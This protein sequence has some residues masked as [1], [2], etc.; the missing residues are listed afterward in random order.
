MKIENSIVFP[1][2]HDFIYQGMIRNYAYLAEWRKIGAGYSEVSILWP[3]KNK[4]ILAP[5]P[6]DNAVIAYSK[7]RFGYEINYVSPQ[8]FTSETAEDFLRDTEAMEAIERFAKKY[9]NIHFVS[10]G[11]TPGAYQLLKKINTFNPACIADMPDELNACTVS[12]YDSKIGFKNLCNKLKLRVPVG[13][14]CDSMKEAIDVMRTLHYNQ[15]SFLLKA[16]RGAA[17]FGNIKIGSAL[18][19]QPF[20]DVEEYITKNIK[21]LP[22]FESGPMLVEEFVEVP[23]YIRHGDSDIRSGFVSA[24]ILANGSTQIIAG[25]VDIHGESGYYEGARLGKG[26]FQEQFLRKLEDIMYRLGN[27]I[28]HNGYRG[29]WGINYMLNKDGEIT[30]IEMNPRRCGES[31][32]HHIARE[33]AGDSWM[34]SVYILNRLPISIKIN[35][36]LKGA[37]YED[38]INIII[39]LNN[40]NK[41]TEII[42]VQLSWVKNKSFPGLGYIII[43]ND[44]KSVNNH[45]ASLLNGLKKIGISTW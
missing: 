11:A 32:I 44:E 33:I 17:G 20:N 23:S 31:H 30:L 5:K 3:G 16:D 12:K 10:W 8:R 40:N 14:L 21:D 18:L 22:Y 9:G 45:E 29:H 15:K 38:I 4:L 42:P 13:Y 41:G 25:G 6:I 36:T 39:G 19:S 43:G 37:V 28:A 24:E 1:N 34:Q 2:V 26:I 27:E 35:N 7:M